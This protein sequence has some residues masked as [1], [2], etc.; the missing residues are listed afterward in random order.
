MPC[1]FQGLD[2]YINTTMFSADVLQ[3]DDALVVVV[4]EYV[5][6]EGGVL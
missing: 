2:G 3:F 5:G 1:L 4:Y 6:S